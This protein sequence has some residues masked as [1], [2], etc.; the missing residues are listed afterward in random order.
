MSS[1]ST[2]R[3]WAP[4]VTS[5]GGGPTTWFDDEY[6]QPAYGE[7]IARALWRLV[8]LDAETRAGAWH[9]PGPERLTRAETA[10]RV[11]TALGLGRDTIASAPTPP[12]LQRP[13][14]LHLLDERA[15]SVIGWNPTR[16]LAP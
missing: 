6:R 10:H 14:D 2:R 13:R 15:R 4:L 1:V 7:E 8:A 11:V 3:P 12:G 5:P 16:I 9:L